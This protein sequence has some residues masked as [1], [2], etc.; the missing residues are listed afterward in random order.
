MI[1]HCDQFC[2]SDHHH[3]HHHPQHYHYLT[4]F[5][6]LGLNLDNPPRLPGSAPALSEC[7]GRTGVC[8]FLLFDSVCLFLYFL[9]AEC[10]GRAGVFCVCFVLYFRLQIFNTESAWGLLMNTKRSWS[11]YIENGHRHLS[12][13][14]AFVFYFFLSLR[15]G[16]SFR[17]S[18]GNNRHL[19]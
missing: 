18:R 1:Y 9:A 13:S 15:F 19:L 4:L 17:L 10:V 8:L 14:G 11:Q 6:T 7:A 2:F 12:R 3:H 5:Q 16:P